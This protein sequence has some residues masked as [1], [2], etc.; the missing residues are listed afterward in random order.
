MKIRRPY[1]LPE[2]KQEAFHRARRLEGWTIFFLLTITVV[3]YLTMGSSQAMKSAWVEDVLSLVP[4]IS[5]LVAARLRDRRPDESHPYGYRKAT[6]LSFLAASAA[7]LV[8]GIYL[9]Y[10]AARS[11]IAM[12]HPSLGHFS[13]FG[14]S[15]DVWS[16]WV[17]I[18]AL[19]YSMIPP[20]VLGR[21]KLPLAEELHEKTLHAD[22]TMNKADW[23]TAGA[24]ILG[25][26]GVGFGLWWADS[27]AAGFIALNIA[28]DGFTNLRRSL[29]DLMDKRPTAVAD[30]CP[31]Q[32]EERVRE[33]VASMPGVRAVAVRLREEGH[34]V[35]GEVFIAFAEGGNVARRAREIAEQ[36]AE[37]DWRLYEL[38]V[39]PVESLE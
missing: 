30:A 21:M 10:D 11:L 24:G 5:F 31:L 27:T 6:L 9:L 39:C 28:R 22:A 29:G 12:E 37:I 15:Y 36:A 33:A 20:I 18:G 23:T 2:A 1:R 26:L 13:L 16:G 35:S 34:V 25:I 32:M 7:V 3:M 17:M 14:S 4:P 38:V 19:V 8:L